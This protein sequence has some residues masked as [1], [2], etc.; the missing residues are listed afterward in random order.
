MIDT[1]PQRTGRATKT[2]ARLTGL[3]GWSLIAIAALH[4]AVFVPQ[5]PWGDWINGSL[6]T[7]EPDMESVA[8]FWA[9]PGGVVVP[10]VLAGLLMIRLARRQERVGLG[11]ALMLCAWNSACLWLVGPS[12]FMLFYVTIGLLVAAAVADRR[13]AGASDS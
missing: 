3:A 6:R 10:G 13:S 8:V 5:A 7:A 2:A 4:T 12:G 11:V 9:L 1:E